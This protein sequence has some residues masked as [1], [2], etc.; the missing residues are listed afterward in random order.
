M[1][2]NM[3]AKKSLK[4]IKQMIR[5]R[6]GDTCRICGLPGSKNKRNVGTLRQRRKDKKFYITRRL[7][8]KNLDVHHLYRSDDDSPSNLVTLCNVCH[9]NL[10]SFKKHR[11][12]I[13]KMQVEQLLATRPK[14]K[15]IF[16]CTECGHALDKKPSKT[17]K[18]NTL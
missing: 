9:I 2:N 3:E 10:H 7:V 6:D 14:K 17:P 11:P 4:A 12:H 15:P 1:K 8:V 5:D 18:S 13:Y 16:R